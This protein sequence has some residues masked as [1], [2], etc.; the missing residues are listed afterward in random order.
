MKTRKSAN[1]IKTFV[2]VFI[3]LAI[4]LSAAVFNFSVTAENA[5]NVWDGSEDYEFE[6]SGAEADPYKITS[7]A[8]L[9]GFAKKYCGEQPLVSEGKYFELTS[10][11]YLN[12][13]SDKDWMYNSPREWV[14]LNIWT[15]NAGVEGFRGRFDGNGYT[16]YGM[17]YANPN[18]WAAVMGLIPM[19]SGNAVIS[20][21]NIR[22]AYINKSSYEGNVGAIVGFV[23]KNADGSASDVKIS[24]C[25]ADSTVDFSGLTNSHAGGIVGPVRE[26][27]ITVEYCGS[28]VKFNNED[29]PAGKG[30]GILANA[31]S[32]AAE[33][34]SIK[35]SYTTAAFTS[36]LPGSDY[37]SIS[38]GTLYSARSWWKENTNVNM[39]VVSNENMLGGKAL[40]NMPLLGWDI[41]QAN[42]GAYPTIKGSTAYN[43]QNPAAYSVWDGSEDYEFEG[44][45]TEADPYKITSAA[46]L[47]GFVKRY[48][49]EQPLVSEGKYF[50]LTSDIY[51]NDVFN[52]NWMYNSPREW[53]FLNIWTINAGVEGFRGRFDGNGYTVYGMYYANPN[54]WAA[55]MGLIPMASGNAVISNVNIRHAYI[56]KSSYE[57][58][59]GAI[60]GFVNKNADGSASDV[61]ISKCVA[62]S[63]VDFSGLTNSHAGGI[64]GPVRESGITVEYCGSS[65]KFNNEDSPAGKGGG[66]LANANSYAAESVSIKNSYTVV[67]FTTGLPGTI[68][69]ASISDETLYSANS[70][71]KNNTKVNM[72]VVSS[73][74]MQGEEAKSNMPLL[75][76]SIWEAHSE[77][78]PIIKGSTAGD[79]SVDNSDGKIGEIWS[80]KTASNYAGGTG[81][82]TDPYII[83]TPEQLY[84]MINE[85][86]VADDPE[87]GAY[88][89][90]AADIYLNDISEQNWY[91]NGTPNK[92]YDIQLL[93]E[94]Q[95]FKG[96]L[97]GNGYTVYGLYYN[98][99]STMGGLI[100]VMAG[101]STVKD[102]HIREAYI[103]GQKNSNMC[104]IGSIAGYVQAGAS[105][106]IVRCSARGIVFGDANGAGGLVG[107][108]S[109]AGLKITSCYFIGELPGLSKYEGGFYSDMWGSVMVNDSYTS[110]CL[111][112]CKSYTI[113]DGIRYATVS[114]SVASDATARAISVTVVSQNEML[115][116]KALNTMPELDWETTWCV[117]ENDYP[118]LI[119]PENPD[120]VNGIPGEVW[121][122]KCAEE[123]AGGSGTEN[124]PYQIATGEQLY[125]LVTEHVISGDK[126][127][128]YVITEDIRLNDTSEENWY[129]KA[130]NNQWYYASGVNSAFAGHIDGQGHIVSG[131]YISSDAANIKGSL[132]PGLD[133][134]AIVKN[135]GI[136]DSYVD[137][138]M[139][140]S[141]V[142]GA[143]LVAY[144]K[145]W[146]ENLEAT[147]ENY[148]VIS[149]CF[150]DSSVIIKARTAAGIVG[151][152]PSP[153]KIQNC[154]A[155][156]R[157]SNGY[158][159]GAII[160]DA[161][162]SGSIIEDCYACTENFDK[163]ADG[164][165]DVV[166]GGISYTDAYVFG[167]TE[168]EVRFAAIDDMLGKS[169]EKGMPG[170]DY[171][172]VWQTVDNST[173]VLRIFYPK[174]N[175][176]TNADG[177]KSTVTF[178]TNVEGLSVKPITGNVGSEL[179]LPAPLR[180]G[181]KFEGWYV[182]P[183]IQWRYTDEFFPYTNLTLY[184]NWE[185]DSI[186]QNFETYTNSEYDIGTDHEYYRPG[187]LGYT[188]DNVHG[189]NKSIHRIGNSSSE[190]QFLINYENEL[191]VGGEYTMTFWIKIN[192][193]NA[194]GNLSVAYK[195]WPD[196]AERDNGREA[197]VS[198]S[199]LKPGEWTECTYSFVAKS[200]WIS[201]VTVGDASIYFDD[202]MIIRTSDKVHY[203]ENLSDEPEDTPAQRPAYE[204][205][206]PQDQNTGDSGEYYE[207]DQ[208]NS[209]TENSKEDKTV[210]DESGFNYW[211][212]IIPVAAVLI[213]AG[214]VISAVAV[215]KRKTKGK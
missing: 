59:V 176:G 199:T 16:V 163:M 168:G 80:G 6:G 127:A 141:E 116:E 208:S 28:S 209:M 180:K 98:D 95:G 175:K 164:K 112:F 166:S 52:S 114:Q 160:G 63:T 213:V 179:K 210:K 64:V 37:S 140:N 172:N 106:S 66:I 135:I 156:C 15:I 35:N 46:E 188:A 24:K 206:L 108:I 105:S 33:S 13:I 110:G 83:E 79:R 94:D 183:E 126:P 57:G 201:F 99:I 144:I 62:D 109:A 89:E 88:Y 76:W 123:Y 104:Y 202:V 138:S 193:E 197:M 49:G 190:D 84:K 103:D 165:G 65:V 8:E 191:T 21:V 200:K 7:A 29:S 75:D 87:P 60:V 177:R 77:D 143:G 117:V 185:Q 30:G 26:S 43:P 9:Y 78:Y 186:I 139:T 85:H 31:N 86:C 154:Y 90:L 192:T 19:A 69:E 73:G 70:W 120:A 17:Y 111:S 74:N 196:I 125:K 161:W 215:K 44:S 12:D 107:A 102:L 134:G 132:I 67:G 195:T 182:Y 128:W 159:G 173:P 121:S 178:V 27:G 169:A 38:D 97:N 122:G 130:E 1:R 68:D 11:I 203:V 157:L 32:Y 3:S 61:K 71:W 131:M 100:P 211:L 20:N 22:H 72:T 34:V 91:N 187:V 53:A 136:T 96:N 39:S 5:V 207:N 158:R 145:Y 56:N 129:E 149:N 45:G 42:D 55:V 170:L 205:Q 36:G 151:G 41:W 119:V 204:A 150:V 142:Y 51:L 118:H 101:S 214:A 194:D 4:I 40:L 81:E 189:G 174:I 54:D 93:S 25:V 50:E 113:A 14:F 92:W 162:N 198:L 167:A 212:I 133:T 18:D 2:S 115:G 152:I 47:Y 146:S 58:N 124:D 171:E 181:Y 137:M 148:P 10:D 82:K 23:N 153:V 155:I 147:E 184:A 48:C